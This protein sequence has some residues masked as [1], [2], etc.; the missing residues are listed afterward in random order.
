MMHYKSSRVL[1]PTV[2]DICERC[3]NQGHCDQEP[4]VGCDFAPK[5]KGGGFSW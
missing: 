4:H 3:L 2:V 5:T 1:P